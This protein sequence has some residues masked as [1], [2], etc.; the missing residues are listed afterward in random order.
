MENWKEQAKTMV[1]NK[2]LTH[3]KTH[4]YGS[5]IMAAIETGEPL[6]IGGNVLNNGLIANLPDDAVVEVPCLVDRNGV[7]GCAVGYLPEQLA[8]LNRWHINVHLMVIEAAL[9][10]RRDAVYQAAYLDP[11]TSAELPLDQIRE[12]CDELLDAEKD[13][14]PEYR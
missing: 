2:K 14:L 10:R 11:H 1:N 6:R 12:M 5:F 3:A 8:G 4:E 9:T 7:Q 13:W